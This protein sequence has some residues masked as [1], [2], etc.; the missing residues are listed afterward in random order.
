MRSNDGN[1]RRRWGLGR[2]GLLLATLLVLALP[3]LAEE[4]RLEFR[5][6]DKS[7]TLTTLEDFRVTY[8]PHAVLSL[9][10]LDEVAIVVTK[11]KAESTIE[12]LYDSVVRS[13]PKDAPCL[14]RMMITVDGGQAA[15]FVV[16][17]MF[18]PNGEAT[19]QTLLTVALHDGHEYNFMIHYPIEREKQGLED[20]YATMNTVKW[21]TA[22]TAPDSSEPTKSATPEGSSQKPSAPTKP[23]PEPA[24]APAKT[25]TKA[26]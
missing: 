6:S 14:G 11:G 2:L 1:V 12:Q 22:A 5:A 18:P 23:S 3:S 24:K 25:A 20:A 9:A 16:E 4:P 8:N 19:H 26:P 15:A 10:S 7:F 21:A 17:N 13:L